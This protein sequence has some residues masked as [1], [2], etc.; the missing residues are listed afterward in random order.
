MGA[1]PLFAV[2]A[3]RTVLNGEYTLRLKDPGGCAAFPR[4][5]RWSA[6]WEQNPLLL[7]PTIITFPTGTLLPVAEGE[8]LEATLEDGVKRSVCVH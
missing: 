2:R 8:E 6:H 3:L 7:I 4:V 1:V 5:T